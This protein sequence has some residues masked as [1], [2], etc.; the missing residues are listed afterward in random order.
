M[1]ES[2]QGRRTRQRCNAINRGLQRQIVSQL[3]M[4]VEI[5]IAERQA[6][7]TLTQLRQRAVAAAPGVARIPQDAGRRCAQSETTVGGTQQQHPTIATHRAARKID[8]H[9]ALATGWKA[10]TSLGTICH[11]QDPP[12][13]FP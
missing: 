3:V 5:F 2:A 10:K 6:I 9:C 11:R 13:D 8:L 1:L 4:V 7:Q 12:L